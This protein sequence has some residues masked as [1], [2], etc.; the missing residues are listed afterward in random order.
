MRSRLHDGARHFVDFGGTGQDF[1]PTVNDSSY[2]HANYFSRFL[3]DRF[4]QLGISKIS[5]F[6]S[7]EKVLVL[8]SALILFCFYHLNVM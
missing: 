5:S 2:G 3:S 7:F 1:V 8:C 6:L 4:F